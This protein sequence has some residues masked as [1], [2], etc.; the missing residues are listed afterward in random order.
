MSDTEIHLVLQD[1]DLVPTEAA[2]QAAVAAV[3]SM[4]PRAA[5]VRATHFGG[6]QFV[7]AMGAF[8]AARCP[9]CGTDLSHPE[10]WW[11]EAMATSHGTGFRERRVVTP[12]C[13]FATTLDELRYEP[14]QAFASFEIVVRE[15][16]RAPPTVAEMERFASALGTVVRAI[17]VH[18]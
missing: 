16:G 3:R 17:F 18:V 11:Q 8:Q 10:P 15:P 1:P 2:Q 9:R 6:V 7:S 12:C 13:S 5:E 4:F 14:T